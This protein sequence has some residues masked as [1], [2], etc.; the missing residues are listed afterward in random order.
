M[1]GITPPTVAF[2]VGGKLQIYVSLIADLRSVLDLRHVVD[3]RHVRTI[4]AHYTTHRQR[5]ALQALEHKQP[6]CNSSQ[7][8]RLERRR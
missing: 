4:T 2:I 3:L 1:S 5:M 6:K 7:L 8:V